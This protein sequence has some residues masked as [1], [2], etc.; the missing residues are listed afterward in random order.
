MR[1]P[2]AYF[3]ILP[4]LILAGICVLAVAFFL[5]YRK[6]VRH[7]FLTA[8]AVGLYFLIYVLMVYETTLPRPFPGLVFTTGALILAIYSIL[9]WDIPLSYLYLLNRPLMGALKRCVAILALLPAASGLALLFLPLGRAASLNAIFPLADLMAAPPALAALIPIA[10][11]A[12]SLK[13][14]ESAGRLAR[15]IFAASGLLF[16]A[17]GFLCRYRLFASSYPQRELAF[18]TT[19]LIW[20]LAATALSVAFGPGESPEG[21]VVSVPDAFIREASLT[22]REAETLELLAGGASY[23]DISTALGVSLPAVKKRISSVYRKSGAANRVEL[24]NIL[25]EY[26]RK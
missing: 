2:E 18:V 20:D 10:A 23:K 14:G 5:R 9:A 8:L 7:F 4:I 6:T 1:A 24:V 16:I 3:W 22:A 25:L 15:A 21:P 19:L 26:S 13:K 17:A 12:A 11:A